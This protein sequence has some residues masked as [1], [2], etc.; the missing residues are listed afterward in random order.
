MGAGCDGG[1]QNGQK[2]YVSYRELICGKTVSTIDG[3]KLTC[4]KVDGAPDNTLLPTGYAVSC[5]HLNG[6]IIL[7]EIT[8]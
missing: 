5:G 1:A 3:Y 6:E 7:L 4:T 2:H 8:E